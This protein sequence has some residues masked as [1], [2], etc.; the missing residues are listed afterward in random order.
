V[1]GK[2]THPGVRGANALRFSGRL[3]RRTLKRG[4][5]RLVARA[6]TGPVVRAAFRIT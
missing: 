1:P 3:G 6:G 4:R 2:V 5:Y